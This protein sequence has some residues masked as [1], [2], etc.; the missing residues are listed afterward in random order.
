MNTLMVKVSVLVEGEEDGYCF[1]TCP[2]LDMYEVILCKLFNEPLQSSSK[3]VE[4]GQGC[5]DQEVI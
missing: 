4:R 1:S 5:T 2:F 3:G